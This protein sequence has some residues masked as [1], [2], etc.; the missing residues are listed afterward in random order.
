[1]VIK[2]QNLSFFFESVNSEKGKVG[3]ISTKNGLS[4]SNSP[5]KSVNIGTAFERNFD[6]NFEHL[7]NKEHSDGPY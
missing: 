2:Y 3:G 5:K 7:L 4:F 1:M 6:Y